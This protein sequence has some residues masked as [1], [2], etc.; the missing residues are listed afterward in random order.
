NCRSE[1]GRS[2]FSGGDGADIQHQFPSSWT[3]VCGHFSPGGIGTT[4]VTATVTS[5]QQSH[6]STARVKQQHDPPV[7]VS[8]S[9]ELILVEDVRVSPEEVTTYNHPGMQAE[10]HVREGSGYFFLNTSTADVVKV[11]SQEAKGVAMHRGPQI[12]VAA[13]RSSLGRQALGPP[14]TCDQNLLLSKTPGT[15]VHFSNLRVI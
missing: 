3:Q 11:A 5:Y 15:S 14:Q 8:A 4:A 12:T 13:P 10:L 6:L 2:R 1:G 7:P 9:I